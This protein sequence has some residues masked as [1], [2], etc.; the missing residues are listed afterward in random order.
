MTTAGESEQQPAPSSPPVS[1]KVQ[2]PS[3]RRYIVVAAIVL[4]FLP[5]AWFAH[6]AWFTGEDPQDR[7]ILATV[8]RGDVED[9]VTATGTLQPRDYVDVGTQVSGQLKIVRVKIGQAV[10]QGDL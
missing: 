7:Y 10:Q 4:L 3:R 5:L 9:A 6:G 1:R 2:A 8:E